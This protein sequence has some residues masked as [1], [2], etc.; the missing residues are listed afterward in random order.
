[1]Q[2]TNEF[3][4]G[5]RV[6]LLGGSSGMG[7]ATAKAAAAAG[8]QVVIVSSQQPRLD[9][10]LQ[11]LPPGS[12]GQAVDLTNEAQVKAFFDQNGAFDHLVYTAGG[13]VLAGNLREVSVEAARAF[14]DLRFW[15]AFT[16]VKY[17]APHLSP[18]GSIVL[19]SGSAGMRP[20]KGSS[21]GASV[22]SATEG[23]ARAMAVE[24]APIRVNVVVPGLV[25]SNLW[26]GM[27]EADRATMYAQRAQELPVQHI[28]EV[29]DLAQTYL[30]LLRQPYSTGQT[31]VV[32]GGGMLI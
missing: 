18:T 32:D 12:R 23:F 9:R 1:M 29:D 16:A 10:A 15:G 31:V 5:K 13:P 22:C 17:A 4:T 14:F 20:G 8:A 6:V 3:L 28:G 19:T 27:S 11:E 7:L 2:T 24:L 25:R 30:Y 21:A 26:A